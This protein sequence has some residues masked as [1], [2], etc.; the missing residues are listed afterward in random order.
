M[1]D[2]PKKGFK[3]SSDAMYIV[4]V[5]I[6]ILNDV[7]LLD[8]PM[9]QESLGSAENKLPFF[10]LVYQL[11]TFCTSPETEFGGEKGNQLL[12]ELILL[13]GLFTLQNHKNQEVV[14]WGKSP[15]ILQQLCT[16]Q[17]VYFSDAK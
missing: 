12:N 9:F 16:L 13:I 8:I 15:A 5:A 7:A 11:L 1:Q 2:G 4:I 14:Q 10:H 3:L 6:K 17:F